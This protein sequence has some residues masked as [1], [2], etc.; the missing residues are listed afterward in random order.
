[1]Y[2]IKKKKN[3]EKKFEVVRDPI[4]SN[5]IKEFSII[6]TSFSNFARVIFF[7]NVFLLKQTMLPTSVEFKFFL[8]VFLISLSSCFLCDLLDNFA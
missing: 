8:M 7:L 2:I 6:S 4:C 1:M 3:W 5:K